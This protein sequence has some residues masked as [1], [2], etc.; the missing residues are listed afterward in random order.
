MAIDSSH[1]GIRTLEDLIEG[2]PGAGVTSGSGNYRIRIRWQH[3]IRIMRSR[4]A[5][6]PLTQVADNVLETLPV[7]TIQ[8]ETLERHHA[9]NI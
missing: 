5:P 9:V 2:A 8:D 4:E 1:R 7:N 3:R 6:F